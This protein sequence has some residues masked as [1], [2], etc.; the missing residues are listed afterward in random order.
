ML[1]AWLGV[2]QALRRALD[3]GRR[4][5]LAEMQQAWP[6]FKASLGAIEMVFSKASP[7]ISATYDNR[8]VPGPLHRL[9]RE[10]RDK[11]AQTVDV[12][13]EVTEH[14]IALQNE[15]VVRR[16]VEVRNTYVMPLNLLQIELLARARSG[17]D[18]QVRD[19]LLIAI[20]GIAAGM[21]NTG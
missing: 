8:L 5:L 9:G 10:L 6:Y 15:P 7:L 16:S 19:A 2:G 21:R 18:D 4:D 14:D 13:L 12:L 1:P 20:N 11:Y 17:D 3:G